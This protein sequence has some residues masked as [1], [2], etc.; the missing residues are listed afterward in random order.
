MFNK[1]PNWR[2]ARGLTS[3]FLAVT[4]VAAGNLHAQEDE[5]LEAFTVTGSRIAR[6]NLEGPNPVF[7]VTRADIDKSGFQTVSDFIRNQPFSG[8]GGLSGNQENTTGN[9]GATAVSLRGVGADATLILVNGRRSA[10]YGFALGGTD[11]FFDLNSIPQAA[12]ERIEILKDGAGAIYGSDAIGGV[13]NVILRKDYEGFETQV[14][15]GNSTASTD[16]GQFWASLSFGARSGGTSI[17][18]NVSYF[19][20]NALFNA[21]RG[22]SRDADQSPRGG[23]DAGSPSGIPGLFQ[24]P[25][26]APG[27]VGVTLPDGVGDFVFAQR[28]AT[29]TGFQL[30]PNDFNYWATQ[31]AAFGDPAYQFFN[32]NPFTIAVPP[33]ER[34]AISLFVNHEINQSL[35]AFAEITF[36]RNESETALAPAPLFNFGLERLT[37]PSSNVY[38]P[39]GVDISG[40]SRYRDLLSGP[41]LS[42]A[43]TD[44]ER[45]VAGLRGSFVDVPINWE[46]GALYSSSNTSEVNTALLRS[47]FNRA[48]NFDGTDAYN[49]FDNVDE[50]DPGNAAAIEAANAVLRAK[51]LYGSTMQV[52][53]AKIDGAAFSLPGGDLGYA[54]GIEYRRESVN[55]DPSPALTSGDVAGRFQ[56]DPSPVSQTLL[57]RNVRS[58]FGEVAI[59]VIGRNQGF[60]FADSLEI[61]LAGR[62]EKYSDVGDKFVPKIAA[63]LQVNQQLL[64]RAGYSEGFRAPSLW[65]V[66]PEYQTTFGAFID[67]PLTGNE[68]LE[69]SLVTRGTADLDPETSE[70]YFAGIVLSPEAVRGLTFST[71]YWRISRKGIAGRPSAQSIVDGNPNDPR[72]IRGADDTILFFDV[73][74]DNVG[75]IKVSGLDFEV[76]YE[77]ETANMGRFDLRFVASRLLRYQ[78]SFDPDSD[79]EEFTGQSTASDAFVRWKGYSRLSWTQGDYSLVGTVNYMGKFRDSVPTGFDDRD[80]N[81][82][83]TLD[84]QGSYNLPWYGGVITVGVRN[85]FD[86]DPPLSINQNQSEGY[87]GGLYDPTG[88]FVYS[89]ISFSF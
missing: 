72:I 41:R 66:N 22:F 27:L 60:D 46:V 11:T 44:F 84:L 3:A 1:K 9:T 81:K 80:V 47:G 89:Q 58:V 12:I 73:T 68:G 54:L 29:A 33:T 69:T 82:H 55:D 49:P 25:V 86:R 31:G 6:I 63:L 64:L 32:Y 50:I 26:T 57:N 75:E 77:W 23:V 59:P 78:E 43:R 2:A 74:L 8:F 17:F 34:H 19:K 83:I 5:E 52:F 70:Q 62:Y 65:Q 4:V 85:L 13:V 71:D 61:Q 56:F 20:R 28:K 18:G 36:N 45:Y 16:E 21:D 38:N 87:V 53:D 51:S 24:I 14:G 37:I 39:F 88:R 30:T 40:S 10:S 42:I 76:R 48:L 35:E 79:L 15:Y 67:D 7:S